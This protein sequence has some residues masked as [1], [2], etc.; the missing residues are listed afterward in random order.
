MTDVPGVTA[1]CIFLGV[2]ASLFVI[3]AP[4]SED[5]DAQF[6]S[7]VVAAAAFAAAYYFNAE[8]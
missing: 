3:A 8:V 1:F 6:F 2:L 4:G 7:A 5:P